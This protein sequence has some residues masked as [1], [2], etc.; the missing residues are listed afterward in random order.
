MWGFVYQLYLNNAIKKKKKRLHVRM[1]QKHI[2]FYR[3]RGIWEKD[4]GWLSAH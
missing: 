3:P 1:S 2:H 4:T